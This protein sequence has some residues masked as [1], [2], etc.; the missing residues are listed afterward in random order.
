MGRP[1]LQCEETYIERP[2]KKMN[3]HDCPC[4]GEKRLVPKHGVFF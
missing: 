2:E 4:F 3:N 1:W